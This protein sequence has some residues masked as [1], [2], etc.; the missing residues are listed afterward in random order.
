M[1]FRVRSVQKNCG[2]FWTTQYSLV[3]TVLRN[4]V[5]TGD[6]PLFPQVLALPAIEG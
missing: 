2:I 1:S 6:R 5:G 4:P 3:A